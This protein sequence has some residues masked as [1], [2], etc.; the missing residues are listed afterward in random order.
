MYLRSAL[1]FG[2]NFFNRKRDYLQKN[3]LLY[4]KK[5][6]LIQILLIMCFNIR[7]ANTSVTVF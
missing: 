5:I 2:E 6:L 1:N 4:K 3:S 7:K